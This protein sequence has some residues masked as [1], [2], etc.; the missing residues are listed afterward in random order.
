MTLL[1]FSA[2]AAPTGLIAFRLNRRQVFSIEIKPAAFLLFE[3]RSLVNLPRLVG[4]ESGHKLNDPCLVI[5][6]PRL[7]V[8]NGEPEPSGVLHTFV[9]RGAIAKIPH[10]GM[11]G[12]DQVVNICE[13]EGGVARSHQRF[14]C[15]SGL[16]TRNIGFTAA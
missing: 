7:R 15:G 4:V 9:E 11:V 8:E 14:G 2:A 13:T 10:C 12:C 3:T 16:L 1:K 6:L 5:G